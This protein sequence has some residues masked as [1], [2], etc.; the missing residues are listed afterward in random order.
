MAGVGEHA[1]EQLWLEVRSDRLDFGQLGHRMLSLAPGIGP[2]EATQPVLPSRSGSHHAKDDVAFFRSV[3]G[4]LV[5][6]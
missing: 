5:G 4:K 1:P 2:A 6:G 3:V